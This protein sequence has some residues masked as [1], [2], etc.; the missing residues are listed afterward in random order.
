MQ[1]E[2]VLLQS[3]RAGTGI[4]L[5]VALLC[6]PSCRRVAPAHT[7][8]RSRGHPASSGTRTFTSWASPSAPPPACTGEL[9]QG[10][11]QL[12]QAPAAAHRLPAGSRQ[13]LTHRTAAVP[14]PLLCP[15]LLLTPQRPVLRHPVQPP[16]PAPASAV[17]QAQGKPLA[18]GSACG[19]LPCF[20]CWG[21]R[22]AA[23]HWQLKCP[24]CL[25]CLLS[26]FC[27]AGATH[28]EH[29]VQRPKNGV[30]AG[31]AA[32]VC[33]RGESEGGRTHTAA[34]QGARC[35]QGLLPSCMW[36]GARMQRM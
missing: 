26:A 27:T 34:G 14:P 20:A 15:P 36:G 18:A 24:A 7:Y 5:T 6:M 29:A 25:H 30:P 31:G 2:I 4:L 35:P 17:P 32:G 21:T 10:A 13:P 12:P 11:A 33:D 19:A 16:D 23:D 22:P 28:A 3:A 8:H 9:Q 1:L